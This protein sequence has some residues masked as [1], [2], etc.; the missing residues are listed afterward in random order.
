[1]LAQRRVT[2]RRGREVEQKQFDA[3]R[4]PMKRIQDTSA[5]IASA[6]VRALTRGEYGIGDVVGAASES[7]G[8]AL[9]EAE[10]SFARANR[11][12]LEPVAQAG[13][14][15]IGIPLLQPMGAVP[16]QMMRTSAAALRQIPISRRQVRGSPQTATPAQAYGPAQRIVD[17]QA[18]VDEGIPEFAPAF[19]SKGLARTGRTIEEVPL[20]GGTVKTPKHAAA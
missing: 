4:T 14:A 17:R 11:D 5:F 8:Q 19:G 3:S 2:M 18:F 9:T 20:V 1:E 6:P 15:A 10:G 16:G 13:E 7:E 12:W